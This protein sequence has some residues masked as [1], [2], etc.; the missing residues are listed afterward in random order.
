MMPIYE[1]EC[2]S[3]HHHLDA[4][5]KMSEAPLVECPGCHQPTL[6]KLISAVAFRLKGS[7]WYET[8]FKKDHQRNLA[9]VD[10]GSPE[11]KSQD[12]ADTQK[13]ETKDSGESKT[14]KSNEKT[15]TDSKT[16]SEPAK[17]GGKSK[18]IA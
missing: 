14:N 10:K 13:S 2:S 16:K 6:K 5:Q 3:C 11:S 8:D 12:K 9:D 17:S 1:Y 18:D 4:L 7:G 15:A